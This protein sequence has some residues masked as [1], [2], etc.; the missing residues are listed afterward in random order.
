M[1]DSVAISVNS[2]EEQ[3]CSASLFCGKAEHLGELAKQKSGLAER[4]SAKARWRARGD[5]K[6]W[7]EG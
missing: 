1:Q 2:A 4:V 5:G 6:R 3:S 7:R